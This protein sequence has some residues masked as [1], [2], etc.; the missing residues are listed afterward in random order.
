MSV[1]FFLFPPVHLFEFF[2]QLTQCWFLQ[3]Q[4][5]NIQVERKQRFTFLEVCFCFR[6]NLVT[7]VILIFV[8]SV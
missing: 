1:V 4:T 5:N 2:F 8:R 3:L 6:R 7:Y